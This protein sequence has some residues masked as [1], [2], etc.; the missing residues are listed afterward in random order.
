MKEKT[1]QWRDLVSFL[2]E[3]ATR[4]GITNEYISN[5]TGLS[6]PAVSRFFKAK[7]K[8]SLQMFLEVAKTVGVNVFLD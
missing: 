7:H 6:Q 2:R 4:K 3:T 5:Q 8:P 1:E